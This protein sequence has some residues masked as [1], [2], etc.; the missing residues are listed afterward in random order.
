MRFPLIRRWA[1]ACL[2]SLVLPVGAWAESPD[3]LDAQAATPA[4]HYQSPL[5]AYQ[6]FSEQPLHN[7]RQANELVGRIGGWRTYAQ[8]PYA[9]EPYSQDVPAPQPAE[10][11][12]EPPA[13]P[14]ESQHDHH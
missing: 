1:F 5:K 2:A 8:E 4:L 14:M 3:P 11:A 12:G 13:K 10:P 6:G 9:Q 7:W